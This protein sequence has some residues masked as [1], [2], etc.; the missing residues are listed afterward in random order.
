MKK[1]T[2]CADSDTDEGDIVE[3]W[4]V[5]WRSAL[6]YC[7]ENEGCGCCIDI[8]NVE[9]PEEALAELPAS[10]VAASDWAGNG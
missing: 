5:K 2:L 1:A 3:Q 10:V 6:A 8:Y 4:L 9:A 7:S